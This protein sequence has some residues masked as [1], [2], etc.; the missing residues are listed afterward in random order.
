MV[1]LV[2]VFPVKSN[3]SKLKNWHISAYSEDTDFILGL[4]ESLCDSPQP[5]HTTVDLWSSSHP[6][7]QYFSSKSKKWSYRFFL[8]F[9]LLNEFPLASLHVRL[10]IASALHRQGFGLLASLYF[11]RFC[12]EIAKISQN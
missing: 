8:Y 9:H 2:F 6:L 11:M 1:F 3:Q 4:I 7:S 10:Q 5:K 12:Q